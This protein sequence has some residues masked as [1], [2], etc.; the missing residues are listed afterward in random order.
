MSSRQEWDERFRSGSHGDPTA[1][2]F[3]DVSRK[4]WELLPRHDAEVKPAALDVACGA[5]R[6]AVALAEGGFAVTAVDF[7]SEGLRKG[8]A[9]AR[10]RG[11]PV[12]WVERDLEL[13]GADLGEGLYDLVVVF[14]FLHRPLFPVLRRCLKRGGVVVYKTF[15]VDQL[16]YAERP[17]HRRYLLEHNELLRAFAGFR[18]LV[19]EEQWEGSGTAA[20]VAQKP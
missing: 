6:H 17:S 20:L 1:D 15:S 5:G 16:R 9:A 13:A 14:F 8:E 19:Y 4:H 2:S 10:Q 3:L 18:V 11:V 12:D 7:S